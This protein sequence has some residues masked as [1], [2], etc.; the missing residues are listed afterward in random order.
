M[1]LS[2]YEAAMQELYSKAGIAYSDIFDYQ[3]ADKAIIF[4]RFYNF[5]QT[6]LTDHCKEA[7]IQ[8]ALFFYNPDGR[9]NA[10]AKQR[11]G[12]YLIEVFMGLIIKLYD[13][14]YN[15]NEAFDVDDSLKQKYVSLLPEDT[16]PGFLMYQVATQ[17]TY[18]HERAHLIQR[19]PLLSQSL[20]EEYLHQPAPVFDMRRHLLEFDADMDAGQF[21]CFHIL[22]YWKKLPA[23]QQNVS[24]ITSLMAMAVSA[25]F[26]FFVFLEGRETPL[27]YAEK[28]H[29]HPIIR[30]SY[31]MDIVSS[32]AEQNL[33]GMGFKAGDVLR[34]AFE[35]SERIALA[36]NRPNPIKR[37][38][39]VFAIEHQNIADYIGILIQES[40][41]V[42]SLV[43]NRFKVDS[44]S[45]TG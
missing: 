16:P 36:N 30:I 44:T 32:V 20:D 22:D 11:N 40:D 18:Y 14:L 35:L 23:G 39:N 6:N 31:L 3:F 19:S 1:E 24:S 8:P 17:F 27:Y 21:I 41:K 45:K 13:H 29:P 26:T 4:D 12:Y 25:I 34:E 42:P 10:R 9:V 33:P 15:Y 28:I 2:R 5:C 43:K 37:Y 7:D 38:S